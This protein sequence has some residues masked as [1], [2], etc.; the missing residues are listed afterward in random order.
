MNTIYEKYAKLLVHYSLGLKKGDKLLISSTYLAEPLIKEVYREA[1]RQGA[2]PETQIS[3]KGLPNIFY[4]H[5]TLAQLRYVSPMYLLAVK[6][7]D[8]FLNIRAPFNVKELETTDPEKKKTVAIAQTQV[9]KLFTKR[10]SSGALRWTLCE[11]PTDSQAQECSLSRGEYEEF[12]FS[13]CLLGSEDPEAEWQKVR[14]SQQGIVDLLNAR[15][16]IRFTGVGIDISFTTRGR[17]WIN[18]DGRHNMPS[19][20]IFTGP[21]EDS[22]EGT[23][24]FSF[25]GIYM[26]QEIE[27]IQLD[28]ERGEVVRWEAKKGKPLL[29]KILE[30]PGA[31]R[32]GEAAIGTNRGISRFTKNMLFDEKM[33]GT[34]HLALGATYPETGGKN[35]SPIHWDLLA[36]MKEGGEIYADGELIYKNG[37][38]LI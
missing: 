25:P 7:Y 8:A 27:D 38:F 5:A 32:F 19:G 23:V 1:L 6:S 3:I 13:A 33:G 22:V 34:I 18:S 17:K 29:D 16:H 31:R 10:A 20:E 14:E 4:D 15:R 30:I 9:K 11:F 36:D 35:E 28:I 21:E 26:G 12:I 24:R 37:T 2:H